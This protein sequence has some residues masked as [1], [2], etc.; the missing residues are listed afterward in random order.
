M[1]KTK[2]SA[3]QASASNPNAQQRP[4]AHRGM[5]DGM[6]KVVCLLVF[7]MVAAGGIALNMHKVSGSLTLFGYSLPKFGDDGLSKDQQRRA[8]M[9]SDMTDAMKAR[10]LQLLA[11]QD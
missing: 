3:Q 1:R 7:L 5:S 2:S 4:V 10:K 8:I 6:L 11:Q 9:E